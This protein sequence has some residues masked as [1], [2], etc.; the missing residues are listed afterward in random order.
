MRVAV[1]GAG[2]IGCRHIRNL[3]GLGVDVIVYDEDRGVHVPETVTMAV[4]IRD[5]CDARPDAVMICTPADSH[6]GNALQLLFSG[7]TGPLFIE[8]P[9]AVLEYDYSV[10]Q[11]WPHPVAMV[12]YNLRFH[13]E[14]Q[15]VKQH[16]TAT[17]MFTLTCDM[18]QWPGSAGHGEP[19]LECSHEI[20]L[21]L[22]CGAKPNVT[23]VK[24]Y[25]S[26][27]FIGLDD[28]Y[29]VRLEW[30]DPQ[31]KRDWSGSNLRIGYQCAF[32]SPEELGEQMY[33]DELT[34]FLRAVEGGPIAPGCTLE[35]GIAVLEV[36]EKVKQ[37]AVSVVK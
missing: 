11:Q 19:V 29:H 36:V 31:Y 37:M 8:K 21:A 7:Y 14:A 2:S 1:I 32:A 4:S 30:H 17:G 16:A 24:R 35:E 28:N 12:G 15:R 22:W 34:H 33:V 6:S 5:M 26:G 20:D 9:L 18:R 27:L 23:Y 25:L 3:T 10:F 13:P